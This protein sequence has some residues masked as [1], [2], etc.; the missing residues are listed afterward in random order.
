M[1]GEVARRLSARTFASLYRRAPRAVSASPQSAARAPAIL[2]AAIDAPVPVQQQTMPWSASAAATARATRALVTGQST[3]VSPAAA[4]ANGPTRT[5]SWPRCSRS[6]TSASVNS[7]FSSLPSAILTSASL[8]RLPRGAAWSVQPPPKAVPRFE[9]TGAASI[10]RVPGVVEGPAGSEAL[11]KV[12]E[13]GFE[14][15]HL[16]EGRIFALGARRK[17]GAKASFDEALRAAASEKNIDRTPDREAA[18]R[19]ERHIPFAAIAG[20]AR[21]PNEPEISQGLEHPADDGRSDA[22]LAV[23]VPL[24]KRAAGALKDEEHVEARGGE[25]KGRESP[26]RHAEASPVRPFEPEKG[27]VHGRR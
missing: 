5:T 13:Q 8:A 16:E 2:L 19:G 17:F 26:T 14:V 24:G 12:V 1:A 3:S 27:G 20:T 25:A 21:A 7:V 11:A 9:A 15:A 23:Q 4:G 18:S 22:E 10:V 6:S